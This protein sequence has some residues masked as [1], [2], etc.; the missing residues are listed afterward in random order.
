M[1]WYKIS[2][3]DLSVKAKFVV[4]VM[5]KLAETGGK[6]TESYRMLEW[7]WETL[8][9][10]SMGSSWI[11]VY[12]REQDNFSFFIVERYYDDEMVHDEKARKIK[13]TT[14]FSSI[15]RTVSEIL[16]A[17]NKINQD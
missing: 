17:V 10:E 7:S 15:S 14:D 11:Q 4:N 5:K 6:L 16:N 2:Q 3:V 12:F 9:D 8:G 13:I 1:K